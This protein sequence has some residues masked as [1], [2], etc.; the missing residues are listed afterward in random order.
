MTTGNHNKGNSETIV[1]AQA[2]THSTGAVNNGE[3]KDTKQQGTFVTHV[4]GSKA[5]R[6]QAIFNEIGGT[7]PRKEVIAR[8]TNE[9]GLS[10]S[11]ASTYY[12]NMKAK[13]GMVHKRVLVTTRVDNIPQ[14]DAL[15]NNSGTRGN[16]M[17]KSGARVHPEITDKVAASGAKK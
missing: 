2:L 10:V 14:G 13:A 6:A 12:Q 11:G 1:S 16:D 7:A 15:A 17:E 9:V 5:E 4:K 8:F 3:M